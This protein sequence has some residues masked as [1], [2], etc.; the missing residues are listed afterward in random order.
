MCRFNTH[1]RSA[2]TAVRPLFF[3]LILEVVRRLPQRARCVTA[4][5]RDYDQLTLVRPPMEGSRI[6]PDKFLFMK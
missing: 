1:N 6:R 4:A 2:R 5:R 3:H